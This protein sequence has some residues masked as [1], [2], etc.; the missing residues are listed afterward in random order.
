[1]PSIGRLGS[2]RYG[3]GGLVRPMSQMGIAREK[4]FANNQILRMAQ[5][6]QSGGLVGGLLHVVNLQKYRFA[7]KRIMYFVEN[8]VVI[9]VE[10]GIAI[11]GNEMKR[12]VKA[13]TGATPWF[14]TGR[15]FSSIDWGLTNVSKGHLTG[16]AW[17]DPSAAPYLGHF[18]AG[19]YPRVGKGQ[20]VPIKFKD[21]R[22][23]FRTHQK[24]KAW[25]R[26][27]YSYGGGTG[28]GF[29]FITLAYNNKVG[30]VRGLINSAI[31]GTMSGSRLGQ[32]T[33]NKAF[34]GATTG[35]F[36]VG[37]PSSYTPMSPEFGKASG[38]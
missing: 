25:N 19:R 18:V 28:Y 2:P 33:S 16:A 38:S 34:I 12:L 30:Q 22:L 3:F 9:A 10:K 15:L 8:T 27:L 1:M 36:R 14:N 17:A 6:A 29:D 7:M 32:A 21:G 4:F 5:V 23:I 11:F 31:R 24:G 26:R 37:V 35:L 13:K 20:V